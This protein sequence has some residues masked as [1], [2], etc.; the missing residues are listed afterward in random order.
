M[1]SEKHLWE[2]DHD[3]Y[4][5]DSMYFAPGGTNDFHHKYSSWEEFKEEWNVYEPGGMNL[6]YRWDWHDWKNSEYWVDPE[7]NPSE[8]VDYEWEDELE[9]FYLLPRKGILVKNSVHVTKDD[10]AAVREWLTPHWEYMR[11]LWSPV[12]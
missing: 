5:P 10:E 4:G 11:D 3:Y 7:T 12:N 9:L 6:V 1:A 2:V 8:E